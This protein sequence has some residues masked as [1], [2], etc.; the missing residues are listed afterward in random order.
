MEKW[1]DL[2]DAGNGGVAS[3]V[4]AW[5][6]KAKDVSVAASAWHTKWN[7]DSAEMALNGFV[8]TEV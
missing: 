2:N 7:S 1:W 4:F 5:W 6:D 3:D 8:G